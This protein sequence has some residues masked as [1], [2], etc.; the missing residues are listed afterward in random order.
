M[1]KMLGIFIAALIGFAG[2][3]LAQITVEAFPNDPQSGPHNYFGVRVTLGQ[4]YGVDVTVNGYIYDEGN[5][6]TTD[7]PFSL[8]VT[9][10]NTTA[11]TSPTFY[12][13]DPT[14]TGIASLASVVT[15]YAGAVITYDANE[16]ILKFNSIGDLNAILDQLD[17]DYDTYNDNY[18]SQYPNLTADELDDMDD[19][20]GFDEFKPFKDF[21]SLFP[22]YASKRAE[23]EYTEATWLSNAFS[24]TDPD[25][26]DLTFDDAGNTIFNSNYSFKIGNDVYQLMSDG[27]YKNSVLLSANIINRGAKDIYGSM[28]TQNSYASIFN[29]YTSSKFSGP[30]I[31]MEESELNSDLSAYSPGP[32][33]KSNKTSHAFGVFGNERYKLKI[34]IHAWGVRTGVKGKV[35]HYKQKGGNWKR[36]RAEMA[37][38][39]GGAVYNN[40][41]SL[42]FNFSDRNP[43]NGWKKR[44]QLK[45]ARH[46]GNA[47]WRTYSGYLTGSFDTPS[48]NSGN[49]P[50]TF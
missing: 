43:S 8:T 19:Q 9:A 25:N 49:L 21:E 34:G 38:F 7:H 48:S 11:E 39:C 23:I 47:T 4:V 30:M 46:E 27:M 50:L 26:V 14:A 10:G 2:Q 45:V 15:S 13:T 20:N 33:C 37:V 22:G 6:P 35:V 1:K 5:A 24:G 3:A 44:K 17:S 32:T 31:S 29:P 16:N 40:G 42:N 36:S 12:Q 18:D 28:F 41:C